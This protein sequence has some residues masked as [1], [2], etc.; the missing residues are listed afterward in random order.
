VQHP[1]FAPFENGCSSHF[2][3]SRHSGVSH[4]AFFVVFP[5]HADSRF[6]P[7]LEHFAGG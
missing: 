5:L 7:S 1:D 6:A 4:R 3:A 2:I